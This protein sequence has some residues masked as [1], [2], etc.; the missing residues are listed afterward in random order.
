MDLA[1]HLFAEPGTTK[2]SE[3]AIIVGLACFFAIA[4]FGFAFSKDKDGG[5]GMWKY[6]SFLPLLL[7]SWY[8]KPYWDY[9]S[10]DFA[11]K[12]GLIGGTAYYAYKA[13]FLVPLIMIVLLGVV[14]VFAKRFI[15]N[16]SRL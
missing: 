15:D 7:A 10:D 14:A 3:L 2:A 5:K 8:G 12:S 4:V 11:Q 13:A 9:A 16:E 1:L 6:F